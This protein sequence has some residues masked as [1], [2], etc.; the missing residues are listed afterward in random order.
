MA[1][2][3]AA[4]QRV[5][6]EHYRVAL[7][8]SGREMVLET[9]QGGA[10]LAWSKPKAA[11][12]V[13]GQQTRLYP[14]P[15]SAPQLSLIWFVFSFLHPA[16]AISDMVRGAERGAVSNLLVADSTPTGSHSLGR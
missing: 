4:S 9:A 11:P 14:N 6:A 10:R 2:A 16:A 15:Y 8:S 12:S 5:A 3:A 13:A 7:R 1:A